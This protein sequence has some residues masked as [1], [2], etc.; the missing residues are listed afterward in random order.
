MDNRKDGFLM[1][2]VMPWHGVGSIFSSIAVTRRLGKA[3]PY[4]P[5][6]VRP[7]KNIRLGAM[8]YPV[9]YM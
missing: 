7:E 2:E 6:A 1:I 4:C 5:Q 9:P 8:A 3:A